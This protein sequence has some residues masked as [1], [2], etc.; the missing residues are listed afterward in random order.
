MSGLECSEIL[1]SELLSDYNKLRLDSEYFQK[2][3][4]EY[5]SVLKNSDF[6]KLG[7]VAFITDG[8]HSSID[9]DE[10][11]NINLISAKSPKE[12]YFDLSSNSYISSKQH[13]ENPRTALKENDVILSTVGTIGNCAV[14]EKNIL[15]ANSDRHIGIIRINERLK[16]YFLSS[17][18][19]SK[20][21]KFQ[22]LRESTGNVQLNLFIYKIKE[23]II[24]LLSMDFQNVIEN[25]CKESFNISEN[26]KTLYS[27][28]EKI[29]LKELDLLDFKPSTENIAI[30]RLK[31]SYLKTGRL[32]SEYYQIK[33]DDIE[34]KIRNYKNG[35]SIIKDEY[36]YVTEKYKNKEDSYSYIE[37]SD[38]DVSNGVSVPHN[39]LFEDLPANAKIKAKKDDLLVSKVRPNRGAV[40]IIED[41]YDVAT[42]LGMILQKD[43]KMRSV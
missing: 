8:I 26:A 38:I 4:I 18:L 20:Y 19:L 28:A 7:D 5:F 15:P 32:D 17:F 29:M 30:K 3:Y 2:K 40:S 39:V 11:S 42:L 13:K 25:I 1:F 24:P 27:D 33:Y 31:D 34:S 43:D 9:F 35:F 41:N 23:L 10:N 22:T 37:I 12:N 14:V 21:G 16:P 6:V 36:Q